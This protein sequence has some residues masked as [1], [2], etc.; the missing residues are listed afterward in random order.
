MRQEVARALDQAREQ[1][2]LV[3]SDPLERALKLPRRTL[4]R[5]RPVERLS[6]PLRG[7]GS[8]R[9]DARAVLAEAV[10]HAL[11]RVDAAGREVECGR[12]ASDQARDIS[13]TARVSERGR[14][15]AREPANRLRRRAIELGGRRPRVTQVRGELGITEELRAALAEPSVAIRTR[16]LEVRTHPSRDDASRELGLLDRREHR[17]ELGVS[18]WRA[19]PQA[20]PRVR[21]LACGEHHGAIELAGMSRQR[22]ARWR[23]VEGE[24][25]NVFLRACVYIRG[26]GSASWLREHGHQSP[27]CRRHH[28]R[29][30][31]ARICPPDQDSAKNQ[32][33]PRVRW[34]SRF[35]SRLGG[36]LARSGASSCARAWSY[37]DLGVAHRRVASAF[38]RTRTRSSRADAS[39]GS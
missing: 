26:R 23:P 32:A 18:P 9:R 33:V 39:D 7:R 25:R 3:T 37:A 27:V 8:W 35:S 38:Q 1:R 17:R 20:G 24:A 4:A 30:T 36:L 31:P 12:N 28:A 11:E 6:E 2:R 13:R 19:R 21:V 16:G 14:V 15:R 34:S 10:R 29:A 5:A 22:V